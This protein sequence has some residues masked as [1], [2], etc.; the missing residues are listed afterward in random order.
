MASIADKAD[1][2]DY[3]MQ[4]VREFCRKGVIPP[5][6]KRERFWYIPDD[7]PKPPMTRHGLCFL[8]DTIYQL[9]HDV[10]FSAIKWGYNEETVKAGYD[11]LI[12]AGFMSTIDTSN[13]D[14]LLV[15]ATV[16]PRGE[17]LIKRE[18]EESKGNV[19]Y[20]AQLGVTGKIGPVDV[21]AQVEL[22]NKE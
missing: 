6:E 18:N 19:N 15:T 21:T 12:G 2:W 16:T 14:T 4:R 20:K 10:D 1:E 22:S 9:N 7:W 8:L 13:L 17:D 5:A 11:Y 3:S